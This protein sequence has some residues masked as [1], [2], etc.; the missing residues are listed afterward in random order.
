MTLLP[1]GISVNGVVDQ[2]ADIAVIGGPVTIHAVRSFRSTRPCSLCAHRV[3]LGDDAIPRSPIHSRHTVAKTLHER[4]QSMAGSAAGAFLAE[5]TIAGAS[6]HGRSCSSCP[7]R[8][9]RVA[10]SPSGPA[11]CMPTVQARV[12]QC[13]EHGHGQLP[14][15]VEE[16]EIAD[17]AEGLQRKGRTRSKAVS[18]LPAQ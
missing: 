17:E 13:S 12:R 11:K 18:T 3:G 4:V 7:A 14:R 5:R 10:S 15:D 16:H 1:V 2:H 9:K 6:R 8:R